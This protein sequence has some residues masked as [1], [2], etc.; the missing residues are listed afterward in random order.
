M[1]SSL[2]AVRVIR[3]VCVDAATHAANGGDWRLG[4]Q[5]HMITHH[6]HFKALTRN[7]VQGFADVGMTI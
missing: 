5:R 1:I 6:T 4:S 3:T 7:Q 2:C